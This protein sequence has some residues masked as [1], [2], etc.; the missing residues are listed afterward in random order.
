MLPL[1]L[2][3]ETPT[4]PVTTSGRF[5]QLHLS[6]TTGVNPHSLYFSSSGL[7][8]TPCPFL[9]LIICGPAG[10]G[11]RTLIN[12]LL[13]EFPQIFGTV[14]SHTTRK[15]RQG[16]RH[17]VDYYFVNKADIDQLVKGGKMASVVSLFGHVYGTS[18]E[19]CERVKN[20]GKIGIVAMEM[21]GAMAL[22]RS[23]FPARFI[24]VA[25]PSLEALAS[26][27]QSRQMDRTIRRYHRPWPVLTGP[28]NRPPAPFECVLVNDDLDVSYAALRRVAM[29]EFTR[30]YQAQVEEERMRL[31]ASYGMMV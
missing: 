19:S 23:K 29:R 6:N 20:E 1:K 24:F 11:K 31:D 7:G 10:V 27:L 3:F 13:K 12:K 17:G 18:I 4:I 2:T 5:P 28:K 15:P 16:E 14:I 22:Y 8:G 21:E 9:P 25:P 30:H 26:R